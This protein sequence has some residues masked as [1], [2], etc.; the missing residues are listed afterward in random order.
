MSNRLETPAF[1]FV[2]GTLRSEMLNPIKEQITADVEWVGEAEIRG[3][4]YDIGTYPGA[5][6]AHDQE[7]SLIKGEIIKLNRPERVLKILDKYEGLTDSSPDDSEYYRSEERIN[8]PDGRELQSWIY[9]YNFSVEGKTRIED[10]DYL[11]YL[12]KKKFT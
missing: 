2:Y 11:A 5:V 10:N 8:L 4:L 12:K 1:L 9:W 3:C 6:P 7:A